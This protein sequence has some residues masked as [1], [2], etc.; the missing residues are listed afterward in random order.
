[1]AC[2][3]AQAED[4]EKSMENGIRRNHKPD[5]LVVL[6]ALAMIGVLGSVLMQVAV[7]AQ[8]HDVPPA[9][10][11]SVLSAQAGTSAASR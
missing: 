6:V 1:M 5:L 4:A 9:V 7:G 10:Y 11:H 8:R 3:Y 2:R